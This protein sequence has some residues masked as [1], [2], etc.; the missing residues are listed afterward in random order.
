MELY[1]YQ[2]QAIDR[3]KKFGDT[4]QIMLNTNPNIFKQTQQS[5]QKKVDFLC[6]CN[7]RPCDG[8]CRKGSGHFRQQFGLDG[9]KWGCTA[10][11]RP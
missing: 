6:T 3:I 1:D 8:I 4:V 9:K 2:Q 11:Y 10:A 7:S 5:Q